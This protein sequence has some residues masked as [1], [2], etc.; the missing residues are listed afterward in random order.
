[1][2]GLGHPKRPIQLPARRI[3]RGERV[4]L[5]QHTLFLHCGF[6]TDGTVREIFIACRLPSSDMAQMLTDQAM[7]VS[8]RL[9]Y[10]PRLRDLV[11]RSEI[12]RKVLDTAIEIE[13]ACA[14]EVTAEY[15]RYV[16]PTVMVAA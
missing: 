15:Q 7:Q 3:S 9:Q 5:P 2:D 16:V 14:A 12:M 6:D 1:M 13:R 10:G 4:E 11:V 8:Y